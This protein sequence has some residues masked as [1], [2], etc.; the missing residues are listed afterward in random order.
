[1]VRQKATSV[2]GFLLMGAVG[3]SGGRVGCHVAH[4][5][6]ARYGEHMTTLTTVRST[7]E[8]TAKSVADTVASTASTVA[9]TVSGYVHK[10]VDFAEARL[11]EI[12]YP[13]ALPTPAEVVDRASA[14]VAS[15][16]AKLPFVDDAAPTAEP[17]PSKTA[18]ATKATKK[19]AA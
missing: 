1:V 14:V 6:V 15:L 5:A 10:G 3:A 19:S 9:E 7:V 8:S 13:A 17:A 12:T 2:V 16:A 18:K 4:Q 11:P